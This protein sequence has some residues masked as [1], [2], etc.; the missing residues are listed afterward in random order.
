MDAD[1]L[2]MMAIDVQKAPYLTLDKVL[3][4]INKAREND[5]LFTGGNNYE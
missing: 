2:L 4:D 3:Q 1:F 5:D